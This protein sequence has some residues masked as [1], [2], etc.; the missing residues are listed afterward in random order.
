MVLAKDTSETAPR[1]KHRPTS[2]VSLDTRLLA[3]MWRNHI[4]LGRLGPNQTHARRLIAIDPALARA[5]IALA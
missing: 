2:M 3:A 4:D 1:E 5:Q